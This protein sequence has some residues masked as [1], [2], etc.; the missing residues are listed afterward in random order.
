MVA[1]VKPAWPGV[2]DGCPF[3]QAAP[4]EE[5]HVLRSWGTCGELIGLVLYS[6]F[7]GLVFWSVEVRLLW[8][9]LDSLSR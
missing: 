1:G 2:W 4:A 8:R 6:P 9:R 3:G 5:R 7:D